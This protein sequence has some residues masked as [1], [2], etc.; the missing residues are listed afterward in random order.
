MDAHDKTRI[1]V[2]M[3]DKLLADLDALAGRARNT[4][5][6][7]V[8]EAVRRFVEDWRAGDD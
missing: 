2:F 7:I 6:A 1:S 5:S 4:R 3:D 8:S